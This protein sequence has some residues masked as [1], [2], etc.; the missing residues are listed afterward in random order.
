MQL[1][2]TGRLL[3]AAL[4]S[5]AAGCQGDESL[6]GEPLAAQ[7]ADAKS[8]C[9][10]RFDGI[11]NCP[12]GNAKLQ[13]TD[14]G[15]QV[16]GLGNAKADGV[17]S[18]FTR[19]SSWSQTTGINFGSTNG[20]L[21]LSA[22]SGDQVVSTLSVSAGREPGSVQ[23]TPNFT[24]APG[25]SSYRMNVYRDG[26]LQGT[27]TNPAA[28]RLVFWNWWDFIRYLVAHADFFQIDIIIWKNGVAQMAEPSNV[29][30]CGWR[31][32]A[33][34]REFTVQLADGTLV[35]GDEV[36]FIE[37]IESGHYP[38]NLFTGIDVNAAAKEFTI[39]DEKIVAAKK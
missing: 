11:T 29:G 26:Q 7:E 3:A 37:E 18:R 6:D 1:N 5:V 2:L 14:K 36:E 31:L 27:T 38:Y 17:A 39:L 21:N 33:D 30:A 19:A 20:S 4:L 10:Q 35:S 22:R 23:V 25:G 28:Q 12:T 32:R 9:V 24:G 15:I 34:D 16:S 13:S 8:D